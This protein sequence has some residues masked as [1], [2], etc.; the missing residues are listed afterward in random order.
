MNTTPELGPWQYFDLT[1]CPTHIR[2]RKQIGRKLVCEQSDSTALVRQFGER[3]SE[4]ISGN[5]DENF[6]WL[7]G[8][9]QPPSRWEIWSLETGSSYLIPLG[10]EHYRLHRADRYFDEKITAEAAGLCVTMLCLNWFSHHCANKSDF[11]PKEFKA[12]ER[13]LHAFFE[14]H[15]NYRQIRAVL[16]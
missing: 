3:L 15:P 13:G 5:I 2:R 9:D 10:H 4:W 7:T 14:I 11:L 1:T 12:I 6:S 16:D 8:G